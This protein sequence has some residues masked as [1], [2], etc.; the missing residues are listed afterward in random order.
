MRRCAPVRH[1]A[2]PA[3]AALKPLIAFALLLTPL[4][5]L[6]GTLQPV[7]LRVHGR[8]VALKTPAVYDGR[9][10]YL[11]LEALSAFKAT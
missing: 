11:P 8:E 7:K 5:A 4:Y 1:P 6:A 9:E 2:T 10:V 3:I